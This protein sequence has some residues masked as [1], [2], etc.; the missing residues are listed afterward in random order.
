LALVYTVASAGHEQTAVASASPGIIDIWGGMEQ[1]IALRAD[2]TVWTWGFNDYGVLGNGLGVTM[3][4]TGTEA[5]ELVPFQ[6][7]GAN[8][9]GHLTSI[10]GI[11]GGERYNAALD[12]NGEVWTWGWNY[13]GILGLG[14]LCPDSNAPACMGT[15]PAKIP[16]FTSVKA[17]AAR[18]YHTL[19]LKNDGTV[20]AW[21][22]NDSGRLGDGTNIDRNSPV[23]VIGLTNTVHGGVIAISG[24][25]QFNIA[26]MADHTLMGWGENSEGAVGN[27]VF[28]AGQYTPTAVSQSTGLTNI[29]A[30]ATGW[31]H[32]VALAA[33]GT[34]WTW[35]DG[36]GGELGD[37]TTTNRNL[38]YHVTTIT[39][40]VG[41]SAG[42]GYT[43]VLKR[44][45]T[46][47]AWG[48]NYFGQLG[49][50]ITSTLPT[51]IPVQVIGLSNVTLVRGRNFNSLAIKSDGTVWAW[52]D[53]S[54]GIGDGTRG[55][56]RTTPVR[57]LFPDFLTRV[58]FLPI[59]MR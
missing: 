36:G 30:I 28:T 34:V 11:A 46:V 27:G 4:Y 56:H 55:E 50:G 47:W 39:D 5:D 52:G 49:N 57:V 22:Y 35:G 59:I 3:F 14:T 15:T 7:L 48:G 44:D 24:G 17:I 32:A 53:N 26:L 2:G 38:P 33:D 10:V 41:V 45:G 6:V 43:I 13:A 37:G 25:G 21:G 23:P 12:K 31:V 19:A 8:G 58:L 18:G 51:T 40:V 42:D 20:W 16:N 29:Q 1:F 54:R 9:V